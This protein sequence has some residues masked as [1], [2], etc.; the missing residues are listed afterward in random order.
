MTQ[1]KQHNQLVQEFIDTNKKTYPNAN[2]T[3]LTFI[4]NVSLAGGLSDIEREAIRKTFRAGY[5]YYFAN[6]L[7]LAFPKG[8]VCWAAPFGH[9][10]FIYDNIPYDIEGCYT[11]ETEMFIPIE[12]LGDAILDF[13]HI[14]NKTYNISEQELATI[15]LKYSE[16]EKK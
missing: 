5:C 8:S 2:N 3:I 15:I 10:V 6:M 14:P 12:Y 1:S 16:S 9:I 13:Q 4:A 7:K 11:G